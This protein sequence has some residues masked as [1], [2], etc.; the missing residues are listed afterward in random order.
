MDI[1]DDEK[2]FM[3][4]YGMLSGKMYSLCIRYTGNTH[5]A[6]DVFQEGLIRLYKNL[7]KYHGSGSF[8]GWARRIFINSCLDHLKNRQKLLFA[9]LS[10]NDQEVPAT[11]LNGIDKV[12]QAD[13]LKIIKQLPTGYRLVVNLYLVEGYSHKEISGML[14]IS[15]GTSKSQLSRARTL[16]QQNISE[17]YG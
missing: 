17:L 5:D 12:T 6:N 1:Q 2:A 9:E 3:E 13:L 8:E 4:I 7:S 14:G 10:E 16:L 11:D 15:E